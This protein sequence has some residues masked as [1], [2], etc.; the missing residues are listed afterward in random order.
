MDDAQHE[1]NAIKSENVEIYEE[2]NKLNYDLDALK[3]HI[4]LINELNNQVDI[5][6]ISIY[7]LKNT[8]LSVFL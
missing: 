7:Y 3:K 2:N 1:L 8:K 6:K 5:I 4:E